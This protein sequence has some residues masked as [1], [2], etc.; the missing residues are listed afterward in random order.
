VKDDRVTDSAEIDPLDRPGEWDIRVTVYR[1]GK[2][3][4]TC[5]TAGWDTFDQAAYWVGEGLTTREVEPHIPR[6]RTR[7]TPPDKS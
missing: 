3:V 7:V 5:D 6:P 4:G 1:N 2:K